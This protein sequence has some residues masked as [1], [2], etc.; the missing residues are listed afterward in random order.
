MVAKKTAK[1]TSK[2]REHWVIL[3]DFVDGWIAEASDGEGFLIT[4]PSK[5]AAENNLESLIDDLNTHGSGGYDGSE[6]MVARL[7]SKT[8]L[9]ED[10]KLKSDQE[11]FIKQEQGVKKAAYLRL[12]G[13]SKFGWFEQSPESK[14][15]ECESCAE[16]LKK[17]PNAEACERCGHLVESGKSCSCQDEDEEIE[18]CPFCGHDFEGNHIECDVCGAYFCDRCDLNGDSDEKLCPDCLKKVEYKIDKDEFITFVENLGYETV[19]NDDLID[20]YL[21]EE[22]ENG[23]PISPDEIKVLSVKLHREIRPPPSKKGKVAGARVDKF[24]LIK[25]P[26]LLEFLDGHDYKIKGKH[27]INEEDDEV[28]ELM[29]HVSKGNKAFMVNLNRPEPVKKAAKKP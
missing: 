19:L 10:I 1:K 4:Y 12:A 6:F 15:E 14:A 26:E 22:D 5:E 24:I 21:Y 8:R 13:G 27:V 29:F 9:G 7:S 23:T 17:D 18:Y 16:T 3:E 20:I 2:T 28:I 11:A 25:R